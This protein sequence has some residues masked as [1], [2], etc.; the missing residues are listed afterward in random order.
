MSRIKPFISLIHSWDT[1]DFRDPPWPK[2]PWP[3]LNTTIQILLKQ[4]LAFL[5][6]YQH[7]KNQFILLIPSWDTANFRVLWPEWP[8]S[9][10]TT[11]TPI[12]FNQLLISMNLYAHAKNQ[13]FSSFCSR[14]I[15]DLK[16]LQSD[17]PAAFWPISQERDFYQVRH[18]C[19]NTAININFLYRPNSEKT[20]D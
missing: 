12:F 16:I 15:V 17:W 9:F 5:S 13:A 2:R 7:T 20:N 8:Q 1:A 4:L 3:F 10:L 19:K 6:F 14:D 18:L 11:P